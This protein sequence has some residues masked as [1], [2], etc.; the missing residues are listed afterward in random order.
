MLIDHN[1][2]C[3]VY[4]IYFTGT[5][6]YRTWRHADESTAYYIYVERE[7]QLSKYI[8]DESW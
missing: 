2:L 5:Y 3:Y 1:I 7:R 6:Y 8:L 4:Y